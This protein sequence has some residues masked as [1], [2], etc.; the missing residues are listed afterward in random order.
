MIA[1]RANMGFGQGVEGYLVEVHTY[2]KCKYD[3]SFHRYSAARF[4]L[5]LVISFNIFPDG[6]EPAS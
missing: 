2:I 3:L 1:S 5:R 6:Q 4:N